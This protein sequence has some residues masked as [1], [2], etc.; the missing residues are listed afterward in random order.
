MEKHER[1][2]NDDA[3]YL[4]WMQQTVK[5]VGRAFDFLVAERGVAASRI[6]L[7]GSSRGAVVATIA[8]AADERFGAFALMHGGHFDF[9]E[10]GHRAAACPANYIGRI[11]PRPLFLFSAENDQDF[12][13]ETAI[14]PMH[15]LARGATIR[16]TPGGHGSSTAEDLGVLAEWLRSNL[17]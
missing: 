9:F 1:L 16:W 6:G 8:G 4:E 10:D 2:Y 12:L 14:R 15:R 11:S 13:P 7:A 17:P 5:D 3:R